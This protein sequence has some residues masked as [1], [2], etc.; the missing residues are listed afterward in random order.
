ML[1][2]GYFKGHGEAIIYGMLPRGPE[3]GNDPLQGLLEG[4]EATYIP[5]RE[6]PDSLYF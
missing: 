5:Q 1:G 2:T 4:L 6:R 3:R